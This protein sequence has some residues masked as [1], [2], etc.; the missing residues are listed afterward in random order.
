MLRGFVR[1]ETRCRSHFVMFITRAKPM[2]EQITMM[3]EALVIDLSNCWKAAIGLS[4]S[5][6]MTKP[7]ERSTRRVSQRFKSPYTVTQTTA[8]AAHISHVMNFVSWWYKKT[9][10]ENE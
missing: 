7:E 1:S 4:D 6:H 2:A 8:S 5:R 9:S 10:S 3:S